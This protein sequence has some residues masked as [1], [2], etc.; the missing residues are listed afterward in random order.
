MTS[1]LVTYYGEI[2]ALSDV[3]SVSVRLPPTASELERCVVDALMN[4]TRYAQRCRTAHS[5]GTHQE[6][7]AKVDDI[8]CET[9]DIVPARHLLDDV[10]AVVQRNALFED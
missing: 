1:T 10:M 7:E 2:S 8:Q 4:A 5:D 6:I 3:Q 9:D